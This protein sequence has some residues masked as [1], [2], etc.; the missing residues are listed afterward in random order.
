MNEETQDREERQEAKKADWI[1]SRAREIAHRRTFEP[2][3]IKEDLLEWLEQDDE[4][5]PALAEV[6]ELAYGSRGTPRAIMS[7]VDIAM[8]AVALEQAYSDYANAEKLGEG[9]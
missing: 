7:I 8:H 3:A 9:I 1:D 2:G 5:L 4:R 6:V